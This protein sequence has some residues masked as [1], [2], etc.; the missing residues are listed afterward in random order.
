MRGYY[1]AELIKYKCRSTNN[2]DNIS[3][4]YIK[5]GETPCLKIDTEVMKKG[6]R[7]G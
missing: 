7:G 5:K 1:I 4:I 3:I 2:A 6:R